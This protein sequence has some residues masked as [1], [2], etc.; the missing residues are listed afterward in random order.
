[1]VIFGKTIAF[2]SMPLYPA[3]DDVMNSWVL[4]DVLLVDDPAIPFIETS[5]FPHDPPI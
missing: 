4:S 5:V 2:T 1:M 3:V